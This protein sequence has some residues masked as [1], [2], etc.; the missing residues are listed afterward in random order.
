M[1]ILPRTGHLLASLGEGDPTF[2]ARSLHDPAVAVAYG[3]R[4]LGLLTQRF[5]GV[6]PL[7]IAAYNAG[8]HN[9]SAWMEGM[10]R[11]TPLDVFTEAI[12][13]VET[14][15]YVR[16]VLLAYDRYVTL[17]GPPDARVVLPAAV[18]GDRPAFVDF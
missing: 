15:N 11:G 17:H 2:T 5:E 3:I 7:A 13:F 18:A 4:Y 9:V 1:Q 16:K 14:R 12:P 6:T 8:P 10:G